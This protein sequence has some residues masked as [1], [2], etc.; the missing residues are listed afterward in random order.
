MPAPK[1]KGELSITLGGVTLDLRYKT[2]NMMVLSEVLGKSLPQLFLEWSEME[3][4]GA[5][6]SDLSF[7]VPCIVAGVSHHKDFRK[8]DV[9]TVEDRVCDLLDMESVKTGKSAIILAAELTEKIFPAVVASI[10]GVDAG[11]EA[12]QAF[13]SAKESGDRGNDESAS[14]PETSPSGEN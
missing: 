4:A 3:D 6:I 2:R 5:K 9:E 13:D 8:L 10:G 7:I 12:Q 14:Q 11:R 1:H